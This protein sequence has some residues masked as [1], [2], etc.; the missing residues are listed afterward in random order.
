ME[1]WREGVGG[2]RRRL[3][4]GR[5]RSPRTTAQRAGGGGLARADLRCAAARRH[6]APRAGGDARALRPDGADRSARRPRA[7]DRERRARSARTGSVHPGGERRLAVRRGR[8]LAARGGVGARARRLRGGGRATRLRPGGH[9]F[10]HRR[11]REDERLRQ[12]ARAASRAVRQ[13][14]LRLGE[15]L[16]Q[17]GRD[18]DGRGAL[19][20]GRFRR[21]ARFRRSPVGHRAVRELGSGQGAQDGRRAR[22]GRASLCSGRMDR[23]RRATP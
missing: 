14:A 22:G 6:R 10:R 9:P 20:P 1:L 16:A 5:V 13:Q 17:C 15:A 3:R 4:V 21:G 8:H 11:G 12:G 23:E 7:S 2:S 19:T 18:S